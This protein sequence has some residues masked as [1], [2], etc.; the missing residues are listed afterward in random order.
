MKTLNS[1]K[2]FEYAMQFCK[3]S[4]ANGKGSDFPTFRQV[5]RKFRV[6]LEE[7]QNAIDDFSADGKK[8]METIVGI[9]TGAGHGY[10]DKVSDYKVEAWDDAVDME[11]FV[12]YN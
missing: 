6:K 12:V 11:D 3:D 9:Q 2:L 7:V 8:Y 5:A 1:N 10:F 4:I